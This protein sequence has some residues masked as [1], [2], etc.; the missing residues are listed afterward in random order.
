MKFRPLTILGSGSDVGKSLV[1]A[2]LC[3]L[4]RQESMRVAP[5]KAQ[6]MP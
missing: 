1:V 5:F 3:R 6:N 2:G 4:F